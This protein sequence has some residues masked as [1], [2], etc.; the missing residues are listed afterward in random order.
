MSERR[1][2]WERLKATR[3]GRWSFG[4]RRIST[5]GVLRFRYQETRVMECSDGYQLYILPDDGIWRMG[6]LV[7][8]GE[9]GREEILETTGKNAGKPHDF[10]WQTLLFLRTAGKARQGTHTHTHSHP[11]HCKAYG[12]PRLRILLL[13][14]SGQLSLLSIV[15]RK[16]H[17]LVLPFLMAEQHRKLATP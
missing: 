8:G 12:I 1:P 14:Y 13:S 4:R 2:R 17:R 5:G 15:S 16:I 7:D 6:Y 3:H 9:R 10:A 11:A